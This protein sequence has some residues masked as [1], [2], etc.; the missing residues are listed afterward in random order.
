MLSYH[1]LLDLAIILISTKVLGIITKK[2]H[3]PQ[4]VGALLAG[5]ILGP[6][7]FGVV[8]E[9]QFIK[10]MAELGVIVL[11][12][13][14]GM[15]VDLKELK[16]CGMAS[17][18]IAFLG[19]IIPLAAGFG[20]ASLFNNNGSFSNQ[21][22]K[23]L[24]ENIFIGVI[25]TATSVSITVE[26]LQEMGKLNT[27]TGT[28]IISAAL[29]DD[30]LGIIA[31]TV[32]TSTTDASIQV[33]TVLIKIVAFFMLAAAVGIAFY[34]FFNSYSQMHGEKR[35]FSIIALSFCLVMA[36]IA[37]HYFGVADITG[38]FI[39]GVAV[40]STQHAH[41]IRRRVGISSYLLLS[42]IFFAHIGISTNL[43]LLNTNA[44]WFSVL[45]VAAAIISKA[46]GCGLG[47]KIFGY[48]RRESLQIGIGMIARA[49]V[50]L[51][52]ANKGI[53]AGIMKDSFLAPIILLVVITSILTPVFLKLTYTDIHNIECIKDIPQSPMI[54]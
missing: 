49:E 7:I 48:T 18:F 46:A 10:Q 24:L 1:F 53:T 8:H 34:Y 37:E 35:R 26:T 33:S 50:A 13:L 20:I 47:A 41:Y 45:L 52:V 38:A 39:A 21:D 25:L 6:T 14:A 15:E 17:L 12:F 16:K 51:I 27:K 19:V 40:S 36:Y 22:M 54:E 3:M 2:V 29:I 5:L 11:M 23:T 30:I 31:L 4:V 44:I 9:T 28:A 42:P 32:I 43:N